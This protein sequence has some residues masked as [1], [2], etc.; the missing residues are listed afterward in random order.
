M[1]RLRLA[2]KL[3]QQVQIALLI[4]RHRQL[5]LIIATTGD[6]TY[7]ALLQ[8]DNLVNQ[9]SAAATI[10]FLTAGK[11]TAANSKLKLVLQSRCSI[12]DSGNIT[13][14]DGDQLYLDSTGNLTKNQAGNPSKATVSGL[15]GNMA[16]D[17][18]AVETTGIQQTHRLRVTVVTAKDEYRYSY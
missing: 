1:R 17:G 5:I 6:F 12:D 9:T 2:I 18:T 7:R 15:L 10:S 13:S 11:T 4:M 3:P 8:L 16:A 14:S